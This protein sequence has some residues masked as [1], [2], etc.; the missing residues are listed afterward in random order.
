MRK[1]HDFFS[2]CRT[3]ALAC[4][5]TLQPIRRFPLDAAIIF[6]DILVVPQALGMEVLM[7]EGVVSERLRKIR[8]SQ[9]PDVQK[10]TKHYLFFFHTKFNTF[11]AAALAGSSRRDPS[12][13]CCRCCHLNFL[14]SHLKFHSAHFDHLNYSM[15]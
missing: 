12:C 6:S 13:S 10:K 3:P 8:S 11:L 4:E 9:L 14:W 1:K 7:K 15:Y 5:I 2:I